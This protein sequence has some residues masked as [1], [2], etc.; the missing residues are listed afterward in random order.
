MTRKPTPVQQTVADRVRCGILPEYLSLKVTGDFDVADIMVPYP[1]ASFE[2]FMIGDVMHTHRCI[3][4]PG[5]QLG[6][7]EL[8]KV[9]R[10]GTVERI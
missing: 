6:R 8:F 7:Y 2:A 5:F 9:A 1:I 10:D 4:E 3:A